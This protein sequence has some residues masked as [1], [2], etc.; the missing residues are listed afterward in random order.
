MKG[1]ACF[2]APIRQGLLMV[3][4]R[5]D[6]TWG[7]FGGHRRN[8]ENTRQCAI[9]EFEEETG[10]H[11]RG[12]LKLLMRHGPYTIFSLVSTQGYSRISKNNETLGFR[13]LEP[14][15]LKTLNLT[16]AFVS[17][18]NSFINRIQMEDAMKT[19]AKGSI[20]LST[21]DAIEI[22]A[23]LKAEKR[24]D[25]AREFAREIFGSR[26]TAQADNEAT[27]DGESVRILNE[28]AQAIIDDLISMI[29]K[30]AEGPVEAD[31]LKKHVMKLLAEKLGLSAQEDVPE[32]SDEGMVEDIEE[33]DEV[34]EEEIEE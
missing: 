21:S 16:K 33:G 22:L 7:L 28:K 32:E 20:A 6:E 1:E 19:V 9:R 34:E 26:I 4:K 11:P 8:G 15:K 13:W 31:I 25:L 14:N 30:K 10:I 5:H 12:R 24:V 18:I 23:T 29:E 3:Q 2:I 27:L 17:Y